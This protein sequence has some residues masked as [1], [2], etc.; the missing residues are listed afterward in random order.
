[1]ARGITRDRAENSI[2]SRPSQE[3]SGKQSMLVDAEY[4]AVEI[5]GRRSFYRLRH[6][7]SW[8]IIIWLSILIIFN[9]G[10]AI[11][12]GSGELN[13]SAYQWF[14]TAVTIETFLQVIA[15]GLIAVKFLFSDGSTAQRDKRSKTSRKKTAGLQPERPRRI[16]DRSEQ[17]P[18]Q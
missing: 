8:A 9:C 13:F 6:K 4:I 5:A 7:W 17:S 12:I 18:D 1:M 2:E 15:L 10:L 3:D 16:A 11:A 14:I